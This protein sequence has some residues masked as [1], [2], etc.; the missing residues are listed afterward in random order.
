[1]NFLKILQQRQILKV[2]AWK[3]IDVVRELAFE[4]RPEM[5]LFC[6]KTTE[7]RL[8]KLNFYKTK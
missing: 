2:H 1:M 6:R 7:I 3:V 4:M 5:L 8:E